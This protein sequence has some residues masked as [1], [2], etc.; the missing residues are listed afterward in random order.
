MYFSQRRS[1][2]KYDEVTMT[3]ILLE[4]AELLRRN[5]LADLDA[6]TQAEL[7]QF[8]TPVSAAEI[9]GDLVSVPETGHLRVLDP[10][11]GSGILSAVVASKIL[12]ANKEITAELVAVERDEKVLPFLKETMSKI[13]QESTG[14]IS[15]KIF[16]ADFILDSIGL[17]ATVDLDECFDIV[18]QNPPYGKL[19]VSSAHRK[20]MRTMG[21][22]APNL[23]AAFLALSILALRTGG[24]VIAIT[25]RSFFNGPY[26]VDFRKY[27]L[28]SLGLTHVHVFDSRS[29]VFSDT[30]VL[31][32]NVIFRGQKGFE[33]SEVRLSVSEDH[34][35]ESRNRVVPYDDVVYPGDP[36]Q[37]IRL[38]TS[39]SDT[40][41]A[42]V[43]LSQPCQLG[44]LS[45]NVS[46][47]KVVDFRNRDA[48]LFES[49]EGA[50]PL[51]YPSN[52]K[53]G[54][55]VW[56]TGGKK[57]QW[58]C[59]KDDNRASLVFPNGW[60]CIV[61]R[62]SSKEEKRRIVAAVWNPSSESPHVAF[63]NHLNVFHLDGQSL[64]ESLAKGLAAWL[65]SEVVDKFFRTFS[66]HTQ[67]NA[68]DL[69]TMRFPT[70][71]MLRVLGEL[72]DPSV[73]TAGLLPN[74][75]SVV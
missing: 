11:A 64:D 56:P 49:T 25:P 34:Q 62:F 37:F 67:V 71:E 53:N 9:L 36:H 40:A 30:G 32:E 70:I 7:G 59:P 57:P 23:Y 46:T 31:Q 27:F 19:A 21:V 61:K 35:S 73:E 55:V 51:V 45:I 74:E 43:M 44:D 50:I 52:I 41:V 10:G 42:E 58:I 54:T 26:F 6:K 66:G 39:E 2:N 1:L 16:H 68:T 47:G 18:I 65:N 69:K 63:E 48:L 5:A 72:S 29:S 38:A 20:A 4:H 3:E 17:H 12:A 28:K 15:T 8:F 60:Y 22:D 13:E 14:R 75:M 33:P 24:Q